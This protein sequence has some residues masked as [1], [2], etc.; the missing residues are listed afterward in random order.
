MALYVYALQENRMSYQDTVSQIREL[1]ERNV[2]SLEIA[3]RLCL[4]L[5]QVR[6]IITTLIARRF[7]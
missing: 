4:D 2:D 7:A 5:T 6:Q 1:V 3:H